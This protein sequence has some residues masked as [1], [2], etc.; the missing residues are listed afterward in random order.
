MI[1]R[2]VI[3][4][5]LGGF[6]REDLAMTVVL[7]WNYF[8]PGTLLFVCSCFSKLLCYGG[9]SNPGLKPDFVAFFPPRNASY[10]CWGRISSFGPFKRR[11]PSA[12][13][14]R[15]DCCESF[16]TTHTPVDVWIGCFKEWVT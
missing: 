15:R 14:Q 7:L 3:G 9:F 13:V 4:E 16:D 10:P 6:F 12:H 11:L 2:P 8:L 1:P 5:S